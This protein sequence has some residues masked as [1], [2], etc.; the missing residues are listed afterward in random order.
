[1]VMGIFVSSR[2]QRVGWVSRRRNP[3]KLHLLSLLSGGCVIQNDG[4]HRWLTLP[5][6]D[7]PHHF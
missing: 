7:I 4:L 6:T 2:F 1:M 5:T 3:S